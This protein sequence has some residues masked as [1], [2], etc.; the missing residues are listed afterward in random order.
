MG[1]KRASPK[2]ALLE[3]LRS[4]SEFFSPKQY[5]LARFIAQ[6]YADLAYSSITELSF[7]TSVSE[8]SVTRFARL[9]GYKGFPGLQEAIRAQIGEENHGHDSLQGVAKAGAEGVRKVIGEIFAL[10]GK[11]ID[12][13][14]R[15]LDAAALERAADLL[16]AAEKV[17]AVAGGLN[18]FLADY[19]TS[20]LS[21][22]RKNVIKLT[23]FDIPDFAAFA[24]MTEN[25][26]VLAFSF[27]RYPTSTNKILEV[28]RKTSSKTKIIVMSDSVLSPAAAYADCLLLTP[29]WTITFIDAYA[30][31]MI[32][33]HALLYAI[34][35]KNGKIAA[36]RVQKYDRYVVDE[37]L[38]GIPQRVNGSR[39]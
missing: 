6:N 34:F 5:I 23:R 3:R 8:P 38:I 16:A 36:K 37:T 17:I 1:G 2:G 19:A 33:T 29:Q 26:A 25:D 24:D 27:P 39:E 18:H 14:Y 12:K 32:L 7:A 31:P 4:R 28:L 10:E 13:T 30:A 9:L 15:G 11:C 21:I 20:Y 22:I 35:L